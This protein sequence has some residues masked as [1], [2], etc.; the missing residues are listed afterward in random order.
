MN[1]EIAKQITSSGIV[2]GKRQVVRGL[3][4]AS[5][6]CVIVALDADEALKTEINCRAKICSVPVLSEGTKSELGH[7]AGIEVSAAVIGILK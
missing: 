6:R 1:E 5:I 4:E 7:V 2:V 3:S